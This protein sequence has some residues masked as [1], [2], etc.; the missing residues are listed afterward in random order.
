MPRRASGDKNVN[1]VDKHV[2]QRLRERRIYMGLSQTA[3]S[4][5]LGITFQQLQKNE[6]GVNRIGASRLYQLS[7]I[8]D[9]PIAYFFDGLPSS[10]RG[11]KKQSAAQTVGVPHLES[12]G[13]VLKLLSAYYSVSDPKLRMKLLELCRALGP[14]D[15]RRGDSKRR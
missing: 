5:R 14:E 12:D 13:E 6:W 4:K 7:K 15:S 3:V 1:A 8:L 11:T 10:T 2:G 9:V